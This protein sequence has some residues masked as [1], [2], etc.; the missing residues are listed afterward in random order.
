MRTSTSNREYLPHTTNDPSKCLLFSLPAELL[1]IIARNLDLTSLL[2]L[3]TICRDIRGALEID[4]LIL[5]LQ[6]CTTSDTIQ[7]GIIEDASC[8]SRHHA[9]LYSFRRKGITSI[10]TNALLQHGA[11]FGY[12]PCGGQFEDSFRKYGV[13][14]E[15][16]FLLEHGASPHEVPCG[17]NK[18]L[19]DSF[20]EYGG[21]PR[22]DLLLEHGASLN[23]NDLL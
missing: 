15:V 5:L 12:I 18:L 7:P 17:I 14:P 8:L 16:N 1:T 4:S 21:G 11:S 22:V 9:L 10:H 2:Q 19:E 20:R 23:L 3:G 6:Q 13:G